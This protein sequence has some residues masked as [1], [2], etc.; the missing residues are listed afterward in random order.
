MPVEM[1]MIDYIIESK[2]KNSRFVEIKL[3]T[4][5]RWNVKSRFMIDLLSNLKTSNN[6]I[7]RRKF[8][9]PVID[10]SVVSSEISTPNPSSE[11]QLLFLAFN[12]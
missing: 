1:Y 4:K 6:T 9:L 11:D 7:T 8:E 2:P 12:L 3:D 10:T 5:N